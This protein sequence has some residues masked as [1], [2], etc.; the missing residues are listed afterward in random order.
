VGGASDSEEESVRADTP[1]DGL[2][3][4]KSMPVGF[5]GRSSPGFL[6]VDIT[7]SLPFVPDKLIFLSRLSSAMEE[8]PRCA[9]AWEPMS[10]KG[11]FGLLLGK[12]EWVGFQKGCPSN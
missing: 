9:G 4:G 11:E 10:R 1:E 12:G 8:K 2:M 5:A 7:G 3:V 6:I